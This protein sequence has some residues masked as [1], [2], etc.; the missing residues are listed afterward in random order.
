MAILATATATS[1]ACENNHAQTA[2][3][4][5]IDETILVSETRSKAIYDQTV[6]Q[7]A[8]SKVTALIA[9]KSWAKPNYGPN[10]AAYF[11]L[12]NNGDKTRYLTGATSKLSKKV[13]LHQHIHAN[14]IMKMRPVTEP[15]A[16][17]PRDTL[18]FAPGGYHVM[19]F[20]MSEKKK[21]GDKFTLMLEFKNGEKLPVDI[22]VANSA[23]GKK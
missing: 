7:G 11:T 16:I 15:L 18:T 10:G 4:S 19:M 1:K 5:V 22:E 20:G 6:Q 17:K 12:R 21:Q 2:L 8:A 9:E 13:E 3:Q 23:P 14:G